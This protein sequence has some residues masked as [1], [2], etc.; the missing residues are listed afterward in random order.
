[1]IRYSIATATSDHHNVQE[2]PSTRPTAT[3]NDHDLRVPNFS[4]SRLTVP[5]ITIQQ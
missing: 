3:D 2:V 1:M 4:I 5:L